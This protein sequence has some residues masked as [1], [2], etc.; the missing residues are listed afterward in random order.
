MFHCAVKDVVRRQWRTY[1]CCG[2][3]RLAENSGR[4]LPK[5]VVHVGCI[6]VSSVDTCNVTMTSGLFWGD[7]MEPHCNA[8]NREEVVGDQTNIPSVFPVQ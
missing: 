8:E 6:M 5:L 3:M 1:L 7:R 4:D 2:K